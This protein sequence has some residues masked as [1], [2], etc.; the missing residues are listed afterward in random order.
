MSRTGYAT[1]EKKK[2]AD[3]ATPSAVMVPSLPHKKRWQDTQS[4]E[5]AGWNRGAH[6]S[7]T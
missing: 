5:F 7:G 4:W 3:G 1:P 6:V 2:A